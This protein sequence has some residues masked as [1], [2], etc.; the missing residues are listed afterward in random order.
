MLGS[1]HLQHK[2]A[3][4]LASARRSGHS[5]RVVRE[6]S[7]IPSRLGIWIQAVR[8]VN[9]WRS[10]GST[11]IAEQK[12][13]ESLRMRDTSEM[14]PHA[15]LAMLESQA[16]MRR[17][18]NADWASTWAAINDVYCMELESMLESCDETD[19]V[20]IAGILGVMSGRRRDFPLDAV[21]EALAAAKRESI[22]TT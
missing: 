16:A 1:I 12:V 19:R 9:Y 6:G 22:L 20:N 5:A 21:S 17:R 11:V 2:H 14:Y 3:D 4:A 15:A 8:E 18:R 7:R 10:H 13:R